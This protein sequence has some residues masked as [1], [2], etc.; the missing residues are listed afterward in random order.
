MLIYILFLLAV[1]VTGSAFQ[2]FARYLYN[3]KLTDDSIQLIALGAVPVMRIRFADISDVRE[4][5]FGQTLKSGPFTLRLGNRIIGG[6][7]LVR[8]RKGLIRSVVLTPDDVPDFLRQIERR[9]TA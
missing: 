6:F 3:Y 2:L 8:K 7:V 9:V 5:S 4:V 1:V